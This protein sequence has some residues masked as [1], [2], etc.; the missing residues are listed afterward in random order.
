MSVS[1][2]PPLSYLTDKKQ[3]INALQLDCNSNS[4]RRLQLT[5][6]CATNHPSRAASCNS[7]RLQLQYC[8]SLVEIPRLLQRMCARVVEHANLQI[9]SHTLAPNLLV[10]TELCKLSLT[11]AMVKSPC[12]CTGPLLHV[13]RCTVLK[14]LGFIKSAKEAFQIKTCV[15]F[16]KSHV[17]NCFMRNLV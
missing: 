7:S 3:L 4:K 8:I 1:L 14:S 13:Y 12:P 17:P 2:G 9:L 15:F 16:P 11:Y 6:H 10:R 5:R